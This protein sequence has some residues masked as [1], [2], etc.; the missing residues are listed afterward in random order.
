MLDGF[1]GRCIRGIPCGSTDPAVIRPD[2][3]PVT[4]A[5]YSRL[6]MTDRSGSTSTL[7]RETLARQLE[8]IRPI[9]T[10]E[11]DGLVLIA[12]GAGNLETAAYLTL[13]SAAAANA[14]EIHE[15]ASGTVPAVDAATKGMPVVLF[16]GDTITGGKQNRIINVTIWLA[17]DK[18]TRIPVSCLEHGRW[19][20]GLRF[21]A[22]RKVDYGM[23]AQ[24]NR[25]VG[26]FARAEAAMPG[27][28]VDRSFR[29]DQGAVWDEIAS[30]EERAGASSGTAA[31]HDLY[32]REA[33]DL[34]A[35]VSA[36]PCP[37]GA[38]GLAVGIGGKLVALEV[39]DAIETLAGQWGRL[40][41]SAASAQLDHRRAVAIGVV[42]KPA[43]RHPDP[44][45]LGRMLKRATAA[46]A[47]A[48]VSPSVGE[49]SDIR[50]AGSRV[51][52][53]ALVRDD[54]VVH[55]ELFRIAG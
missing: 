3:Q 24:V 44:G 54:Q 45:A 26:E 20:N 17:A 55:L 53:S 35:Y 37:P 1:G 40:V 29:A 15:L 39:F 21:A 36:F 11:R 2:T 16:A 47:D 14:V 10:M 7:P 6:E 22:G 43:H 38:S 33:G 34:A 31:L 52:G 9:V 8:A 41:E 19:D 27:P 5:A 25:S 30:K 12:L 32:A 50:L 4:A 49:G 48:V 13:E 18:T 42:P 23:R 28:S 51:T 46:L